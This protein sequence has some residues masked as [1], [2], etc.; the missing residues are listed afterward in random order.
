MTT[1]IRGGTVVNADQAFRA[2][3][4]C[5]GDKIIAVGENLV[6]PAQAQ[7]IDASGQYVMPGGI[8]PHTH[9]QLPFMGTVT[10]DDFF[11][12]TAAGLA[13]G[14]TTI[15]DFV[16]PSQQQ[17]LLDAYHTWRGW[18]KKSAGDYTFHVAVT[19][20]DDTVHADMGTLVGEHGVNSFK[21]FMAYK[22]AIMA[23][24][25][26]LIK[27]FTRALELGAMPTV[28]AE[29]GELVFQLQQELLK[30]GMTGPAGHALSRPPAVEAEA[31]NRAVAIANVIGTPVYIVHVSCA[32]ALEAIT[33]AR[34]NGQRVYGEALAGHLVT[35]D[36]VYHSSD[37]EFAA[38]HVM[39]PPFR[40][41]HHQDAL[42]RGLQGGNLQT[43]AT[44]HC[45]F[46]AAQKAAGRDDFAKIPNGCGGIEDRMAVLWDAGVNT[47]KLTPSEF[48]RV[49]SANAAQIF[50]IYPR[51][52][53]VAVGADADLV[54]W[55]PQGSRT[56]SAK[57]QFSKGDFNVFEGRTVQGIPTHTLA[58]GKLVFRHGE[59]R[60]VAGAGRYVDRPAFAPQ[61][62][63]R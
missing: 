2:D 34:A 48:V 21:H 63:K 16:I 7:V 42:W 20:W 57:T 54:V 4:L 23:D 49:T 61:S 53:V 52:G 33:R 18:A 39:S 3:V 44:D 19:W 47:G 51:K 46:C 13:G 31:T 62:A 10:A 58:A 43:T 28:H 35:D 50:N 17:S 37:L 38:A 29:N 26:I 36:S 41:R 11:T 60:A 12:G 14:T 59:L 22:H 27:S 9:M 6:A 56:I 1:I 40:A 32:E 15:M 24:D 8:D 25:E 30:K 45:V 55:D 5:H